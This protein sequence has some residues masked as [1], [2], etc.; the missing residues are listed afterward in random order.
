[1]IKQALYPTKVRKHKE[2]EIDYFYK[3]SLR[4]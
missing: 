1:L 2:G 4:K 3:D